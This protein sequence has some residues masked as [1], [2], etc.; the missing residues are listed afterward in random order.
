MCGIA[1]I[2]NYKKHAS[3][4]DRDE[5]ISISERMASRGPDGNGLWVSSDC[6]VGLSHRRLSIID[7]S[8]SGGQPMLDPLTGNQ[9]VFNGEIYNYLELRKELESL[10]CSFHSSSDTEVLLL[11]YSQFGPDMLHKLRGMYAFAIYDNIQKGL[12]LARD[13][14]GIKPLYISDDGN[15]LRFASQVKALVAGGQIDN[16]PDEAGHVGF[17]LWGFVPEPYTLYRAI[18]SFPAGTSLWVS[19]DGKQKQECFFDL[20]DE[21]LSSFGGGKTISREEA[22]EEL[23]SAMLDS[24]RLHLR[25]DVPFGLFLSAGLDSATLLALTSEC[26]SDRK[27]INTITLAFE[28]FFGTSDD[29]SSLAEEL[30]TRFG[31]S[32][33]RKIINQCDFDQQLDAL[34]SA[35]DQPSVDGVNSF[36]VCK[37][38]R[39]SGLKLAL[40]GL[41]G[42]ELFGGYG[43][44][45][46]IPFM[47]RLLKPFSFF[48]ELSVL[49][50]KLT[51]PII[52]KFRLSPKISSLLEYG[53]DTA[54]AYF[55]HRSLFM[56][57]ELEDLF[58]EDFLF[59][60]LSEL[61]TV[62]ALKRTIH[63]LSNDHDKIGA[64][65]MRWYM[66]GQLLRDTD[67]ASMAHGVEV[68]VP[69][70]DIE[71][72]RAVLRVSGAGRHLSKGDMASTPLHEQQDSILKRKKTGFSIPVQDWAIKDALKNGSFLST[73]KGYRGWAKEVYS[74]QDI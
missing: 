5:L 15:T 20:S 45:N 4:V 41:G 46:T 12:F 3:P 53:G 35:M 44:F 7:L 13:P 26:V 68:R 71:L 33:R 64:L 9:I 29:E 74:R 34:F 66:Q 43:H 36:F 2:F 72:F 24:V 70:V 1:G 47:R 25:A 57:W 18:H 14:F 62:P 21:Y 48:P 51:V 16:R 38:A 30:A 31:S 27:K 22:H 69:L 54:G 10:G 28:E 6:C 50:R 37:A 49:V 19:C 11:L 63:G 60:G 65:E 42:D 61:R 73:E 55:L 17:F 39:E 59:E 32:H 23:R 8:D 58:S 52:R 40:S 56:P 67:W